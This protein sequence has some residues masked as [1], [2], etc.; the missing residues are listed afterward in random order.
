MGQMTVRTAIRVVSMS[1]ADTRRRTFVK[2]ACDARNEWEFFSAYS[3]VVAPLAYDQRLTRKRFGR[4]LH[5]GELGCYASHYKLW[6]WFSAS[7]FEQLIV[8]EDDVL[9]DWMAINE[10]AR[11]NLSA[12]GIDLVKLYATHDFKIK[13]KLYRFAS[14]HAHLLRVKGLILGTQGYVVSKNAARELLRVAKQVYLPIDWVMARY[15][16]YGVPNYCYFP[17][18]VIERF[19]PSAIGDERH[20]S[21]PSPLLDRASRLQWRIIDRVRRE[22]LEAAISRKAIRRNQDDGPAFLAGDMNPS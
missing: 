15:W 10:I 17:F 19:V 6:E 5:P 13:E 2:N 22:F 16:D 20:A 8:F 1:D 11:H 7:E 3:G 18:P 9:I 14:P 4:D 12:L 21:V